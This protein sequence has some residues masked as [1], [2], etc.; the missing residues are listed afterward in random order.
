MID[1]MEIERHIIVL[2]IERLLLPL[3][4]M[5][6]ALCRVMLATLLNLDMCLLLDGTIGL[7][8]GMQKETIVHSI[9]PMIV[10]GIWI[11][12]GVSLLLC[13]QT[14]HVV[15]SYQVLGHLDQDILHRLNM[16]RLGEL[17]LV[18]CTTNTLCLHPM[19]LVPMNVILMLNLCRL[20]LAHTLVIHPGYA[21][22]V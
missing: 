4:P 18:S 8:N 20:C 1:H 11:G 2:P 15:Q 22:E 14:T 3:Q 21:R 17:Q 13:L 19:I 9:D 7:E 10:I 12:I 6:A 16:L 5:I